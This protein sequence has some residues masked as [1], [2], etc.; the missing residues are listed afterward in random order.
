MDDLTPLG[1]PRGDVDV[2]PSLNPQGWPLSQPEFDVYSGANGDLISSP[3]WHNVC[4]IRVYG[5]FVGRCRHQWTSLAGATVE[6]LKQ[7]GYRV[8][9]RPS[10]A[11]FFAA[12][13]AGSEG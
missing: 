7:A 5:T 1:D 6:A 3:K 11:A 2:R 13:R 9:Y 12:G 8:D 4:Y 10:D